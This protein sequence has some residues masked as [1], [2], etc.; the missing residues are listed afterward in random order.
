[1]IE[2]VRKKLFSGQYSL[3]ADEQEVAVLKIAC[4]KAEL[5]YAKSRYTMRMQGWLN[6]KHIL[7]GDA[8]RI[9]QSANSGVFRTFRQLEYADKRY[10]IKV[11]SGRNLHSSV[12]NSIE[13]YD[14]TK[15]I[16]SVRSQDWLQKRVFID[17][18]YDWPIPV[19][20]FIFWIGLPLM[21]PG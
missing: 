8:I 19:Q 7:E 21:S 3:R 13:I 12:Y 1:M 9:V 16:G 6:Q 14:G 4:R 20:A 15:K 10:E 2:A 18:P 11:A 5:K 17:L